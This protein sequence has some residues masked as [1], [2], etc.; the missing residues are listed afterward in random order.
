[1]KKVFEV[2][3]HLSDK[4]RLTAAF[5]NHKFIRSIAANSSRGTDFRSPEPRRAGVFCMSCNICS[6]YVAEYKGRGS[7]DRVDF[8]FYVNCSLIIPKYVPSPRLANI[9]N[10]HFA[11]CSAEELP[12][13]V[14]RFGWH[15]E[16]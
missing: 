9:L 11:R 13:P 16:S 15:K 1:M 5:M 10:M 14:A 2:H 8:C 12:F 4:L 7:R 6:V 3:L